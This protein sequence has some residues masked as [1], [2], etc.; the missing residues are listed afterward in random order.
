MVHKY[1]AIHRTLHRIADPFCALVHI[2][3]AQ[4]VGQLGDEAAYF[5]G[6]LLAGGL[7][8]ARANS[9]HLVQTIGRPRAEQVVAGYAN[10]IEVMKPERLSQLLNI[11]LAIFE[12]LTDQLARKRV[13]YFY[14]NS[15]LRVHAIHHFNV[16]SGLCKRSCYVPR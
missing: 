7:F 13:G 1:L 15:F 6:T 16:S 9:R 10:R 8:E 11:A 4:V 14:W 12:I 5:F 3:V 2:D